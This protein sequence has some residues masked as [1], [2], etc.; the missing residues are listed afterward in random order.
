METWLEGGRALDQR[1]I[2]GVLRQTQR[3]QVG[4]R[5]EGC[6]GTKPGQTTPGDKGQGREG[7]SKGYGE[8]KGRGRSHLVRSA[9]KAP[10]YLF[11]PSLR[12][13]LTTLV[14]GAK[15]TITFNAT[16]G[17]WPRRNG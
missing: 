7:F 10:V 9:S 11:A 6:V 8:A 14:F 15:P 16:R 13:S 17:T 1:P 2:P 5:S 4:C 12:P 3:Q